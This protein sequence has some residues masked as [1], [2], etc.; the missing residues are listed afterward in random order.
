MMII[1]GKNGLP[2]VVQLPGIRPMHEH[3]SPCP[4]LEGQANEQRFQRERI[5]RAILQANGVVGDKLLKL[6][7]TR[8]YKILGWE[9]RAHFQNPSLVA[10]FRRGWEG[11]FAQLVEAAWQAT[12]QARAAVLYLPNIISSRQVLIFMGNDPS[13]ARVENYGIDP[14][15]L[16]SRTW[17]QA[18]A[19]LPLGNRENR[20]GAVVLAWRTPNPLDPLIH[21]QLLAGIT[22]DLTRVFTQKPHF[23]V[24]RF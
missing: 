14:A 3:Q 8:L 4:P 1:E 13:S 12:P 19:A 6:D 22:I 7:Q 9:L 24:N 10:T 17:Y 15:E 23:L 21:L 5:F 11:H 18:A 20:L 16:K 2:G